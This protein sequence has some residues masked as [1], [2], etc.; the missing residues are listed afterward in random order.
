MTRERALIN[1]L[2]IIE[3]CRIYGNEHRCDQCP[4]YI[5][6]CMVTDGNNIPTDWKAAEIVEAIERRGR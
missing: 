5:N 6:G 1:A 3:T 2:E 4:Y